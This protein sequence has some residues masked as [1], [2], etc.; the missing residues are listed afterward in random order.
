MVFVAVATNGEIIPCGEVAAVSRDAALFR[1][2]GG[3][4]VVRRATPG[5]AAAL[6]RHWACVEHA[7]TRAE[8]VREFKSICLRGE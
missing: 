6:R 8:A 7:Q 5:D 3:Q 4:V 2:Y 1:P